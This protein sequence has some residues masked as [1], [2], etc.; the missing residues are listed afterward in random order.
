MQLS[1]GD[2][3]GEILRGDMNGD[4]RDELIVEMNKIVA[5]LTVYGYMGNRLGTFLLDCKINNAVCGD[6]DGDKRD[7]LLNIEFGCLAAY[8]L[9]QERREVD[10]WPPGCYP[11]A[12]RDIDGDGVDEVIACHTRMISPE[13]YDPVTRQY[14]G[15]SKDIGEK[16]FEVWVAKHAAPQ[17][18]IFFPRTGRFVPLQFPDANWRMNILTGDRGEVICTDYDRDGR[19][20][21]LAKAMVGTMLMAFGEGGR[22]EYR[23]EFGEPAFGLSLARTG[24]REYVVVQLAKRLIVTP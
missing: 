3:D 7:E 5:Q 8:G 9:G 19:I 10:G 1:Q 23:E 6:V 12:C 18:G 24:K 11:S 16:Q 15:L 2:D 22:L 13:N 20:E 17:G 14:K 21:V 4:G